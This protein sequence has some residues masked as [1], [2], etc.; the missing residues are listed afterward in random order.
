MTTALASKANQL[1]MTVA[2]LEKQH[3]FGL[4]AP[5]TW[6]LNPATE[7]VDLMVDSYSKS[8]VDNAITS[9]QPT[10]PVAAPTNGF[11]LVVD[12]SRKGLAL[13]HL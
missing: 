10:L 1:D 6:S 13:I 8:E 11:P 3:K 5:L 7:S 9:L 4:V 12:G 2:L